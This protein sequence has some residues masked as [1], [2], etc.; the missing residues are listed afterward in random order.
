MTYHVSNQNEVHWV[1]QML[2]LGGLLPVCHYGVVAVKLT[3]YAPPPTTAREQVFSGE[4]YITLVVEKLNGE[5]IINRN[6]NPV[7]AEYARYYLFLKDVGEGVGQARID[8]GVWEFYTQFIDDGS[9]IRNG[10]A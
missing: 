10:H 5:M 9:F 1:P 6:R 8:R 4:A 7:K 3:Y 2:T